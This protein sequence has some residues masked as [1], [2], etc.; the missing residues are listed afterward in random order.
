MS[1]GMITRGGGRITA[2]A[3]GAILATAGLA[4]AA[5][6]AA[7]VPKDA[8]P[9]AAEVAANSAPDF[10]ETV[11]LEED[12]ADGE[13]PDGWAPAV[14]DWEVVDHRLQSTTGDEAARIGFGP[15]APENFRLEVSAEFVEVENPAR[16]LSVGLDYHA[17]EHWGAWVGL[18]SETSADNGVEFV[19]RP[20]SGSNVLSTYPGPFDLGTGEAHDLTFEVHGSSLDVSIDGEDVMSTDEMD[21]TGGDFG[22]RYSRATVAFDDVRITEIAPRASGASA[23]QN[24]HLNENGEDATITWDAPADPGA[25]EE[26]QPAT[27]T[28][29]EV[30]S[31]GA[32]AS[33][34]EL[35]WVPAETDSSHTFTGLPGDGEQMLRV[36]ATNSS[37]LHG[38]EA[39][40]VTMRGADTVDGYK[41]E[42]HNGPWPTSHVQGIAVDE[43]QGYIY[44]SF[45]TLLVKTDLAG[46]I[47]G[48]VGGFTGHLGDLDFNPEDGRVYGSLEYKDAE[49]FYIA[50]VDVDEIDEIGMDAQN[51]PVVSTVYLEE[52]VEDYTADMDG[53][54]VFDGDTGD[55]ADHRYGCSGIDGVAFG[56]AFGSTDGDPYLT[57][58][59]GIYSNT[60]RDDN[61]H[62][63]LLQYDTSTWAELEQPLTEDDPH[64]VGPETVAG[65]Y[66]VFTGNTTYGVQNLE[67]DPWLDRWFMGV[68]VGKK[69]TYPNYRLFAVDAEDAASE[70]PLEG[71]DGEEGML[72]PLADDGLLDEAT[73]IRGW[74]Q[75]ASVGFQAL[76]GGLYY[77][78]TATT[79]GGQ[80]STLT[81]ET[82]TGDAE[83]PFVPVDVDFEPLPRWDDETTYTGGETVAY[84]RSVWLASWWTR[85]QPPGDPNGPWQ[86]IV[87]TAAGTAV[88][89]PSR[90]FEDGDV[91][92]HDGTRYEAQWWTRNEEPGAANG[93]WRAID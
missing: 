51:S 59:Y 48:T 76:G 28:G 10:E 11:L 42:L 50:I 86:E 68:Y 53:D 77:I 58:A 82:W 2:A 83:D 88:W 21:R 37:G 17:E 12:F 34:G 43:Q 57:V 56:P 66:F 36:R 90:I 38:A 91:A 32:D 16:W 67:F 54:G 63:V 23:P 26:G 31:D 35:V 41:L 93:P 84:D 65:K 80:G 20:Q 19:Q 30:T 75:D 47:V 73:G 89:T 1:T 62:Q 81:L 49:A 39:S 27:I 8:L 45:T 87:T 46:N 13:L 85:D 33:S 44:Y 3:L 7:A 15:Q 4:T 6:P 61:D 64:H 29:Y 55:T 14:G 69:E 60:E 78:S 79:D 9:P 52:V 25:D 18:R 40:V 5:G 24:V 70:Q 22:F 92:S 71:L 72:L 74:Q